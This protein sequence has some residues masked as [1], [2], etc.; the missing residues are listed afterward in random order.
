[1]ILKKFCIIRKWSFVYFQYQNFFWIQ[2]SK[3]SNFLFIHENSLTLSENISKMTLR[4]PEHCDFPF[5]SCIYPHTNHRQTSINDESFR[6]A[7]LSVLDGPWMIS[8]RAGNLLF[9]QDAVWHRVPSVNYWILLNF[10]IYWYYWTFIRIMISNDISNLA[11]KVC[12]QLSDMG[13]TNETVLQG[14]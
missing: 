1:M 13:I 9:S 6:T 4:L 3:F 10:Q 5:D 14:I 12:T 7:V 11:K 2:K 8:L